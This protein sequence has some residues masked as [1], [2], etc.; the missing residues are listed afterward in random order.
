MIEFEKSHS[1]NNKTLFNLSDSDEM[2]A[3]IPK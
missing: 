2:I 1:A 3:S